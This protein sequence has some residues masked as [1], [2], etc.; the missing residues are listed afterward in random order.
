MEGILIN[1]RMKT[2]N[3]KTKDEQPGCGNGGVG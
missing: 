1:K 2:K 3:M